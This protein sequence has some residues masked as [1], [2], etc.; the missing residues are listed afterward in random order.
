MA[1]VIIRCNN[2]CTGIKYK[3]QG[4]KKSDFTPQVR[5]PENVRERFLVGVIP[6]LGFEGSGWVRLNAVT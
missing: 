3:A 4:N 5:M 1:T 6:A 2:C